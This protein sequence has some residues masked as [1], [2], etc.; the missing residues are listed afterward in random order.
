MR[1]K[2]FILCAFR[3]SY[4]H[5]ISVSELLGRLSYFIVDLLSPVSPTSPEKGK[6]FHR[7]LKTSCHCYVKKSN[8]CH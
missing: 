7:I 1:K 8:L 4:K 5:L 6:A 2:D 3:D